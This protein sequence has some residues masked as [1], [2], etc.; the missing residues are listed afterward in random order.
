M[1]PMLLFALTNEGTERTEDF[2]KCFL[3]C[4]YYCLG[5]PMTSKIFP[6]LGSCSDFPPGERA[7]E[8]S[9]LSPVP[10][11]TVRISRSAQGAAGPHAGA[12]AAGARGDRVALRLWILLCSDTYLL[13]S[14]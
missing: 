8:R 7:R 11:R 9:G 1:K 14:G 12:R 3:N 2:K 13:G 6:V 10:A 4:G 5:L